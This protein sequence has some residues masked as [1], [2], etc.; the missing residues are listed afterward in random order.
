MPHL[1]RPA[2]RNPRQPRRRHLHRPSGH[3]RDRRSPRAVLRRRRVPHRRRT[4]SPTT[5]RTWPPTMRALAGRRRGRVPGRGGGDA[6][7]AKT[8]RICNPTPSAANT[9]QPLPARRLGRLPT[10]HSAPSLPRYPGTRAEPGDPAAAVQAALGRPTWRRRHRRYRRDRLHR[11][12][13]GADRAGDRRRRPAHQGRRPNSA[14]CQPPAAAMNT[15][16]TLSRWKR[17]AAVTPRLV[18][19]RPWRVTRVGMSRTGRASC[20][21]GAVDSSALLFA[22]P[23][24]RIMSDSVLTKPRALSGSLLAAKEKR[25]LEDK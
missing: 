25:P 13:Q 24:Q 11:R 19:H 17:T 10:A 20:R 1:R 18:G 23:C 15:A 14:S 9:A 2:D 6:S 4:A 7:G 22:S 21:I 5:P 12:P 16:L 8:E 3:R